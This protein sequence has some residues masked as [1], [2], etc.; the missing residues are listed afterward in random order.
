VLLRPA[1]RDAARVEAELVGVAPA[2]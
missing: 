1:E 2:R